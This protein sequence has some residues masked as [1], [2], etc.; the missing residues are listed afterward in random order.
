MLEHAY[1]APSG[2]EKPEKEAVFYLLEA[3]FE[4]VQVL[5]EPFNFSSQR[6]TSRSGPFAAM[7]GPKTAGARTHWTGR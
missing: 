6:V 7:C 5:R 2:T 3:I 1:R 4:T